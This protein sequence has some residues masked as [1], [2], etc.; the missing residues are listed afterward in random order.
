[1][2]SICVLGNGWK[3]IVYR[4]LGENNRIIRPRRN[5][6]ISKVKWLPFTMYKDRHKIICVAES[7]I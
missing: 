1:M 6:S 4:I 2:S 5:L 7:L 3:T